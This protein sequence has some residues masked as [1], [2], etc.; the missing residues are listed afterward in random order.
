MDLVIDLPV[1]RLESHVR[2]VETLR[3]SCDVDLTAT[4]YMVA[5]TERTGRYKMVVSSSFFS[6][7]KI[8]ASGGS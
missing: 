2:H 3:R 4:S 7:Y 1:R 8:Y 6:M 5:A